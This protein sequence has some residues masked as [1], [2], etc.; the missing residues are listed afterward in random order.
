MEY[1]FLFIPVKLTVIVDEEMTKKDFY[2]CTG[3]PDSSYDIPGF[4]EVLSLQCWYFG[5]RRY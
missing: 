1:D 2:D 4:I 5:I 3:L